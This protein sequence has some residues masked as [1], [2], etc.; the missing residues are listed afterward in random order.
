MP[1]MCNIRVRTLQVVLQIPIG[2]DGEQVATATAF[3]GSLYEPI[4]PDSTSAPK[5]STD[6]G[7]KEAVGKTTTTTTTAAT[8]SRTWAP[9]EE[10]QVPAAATAHL[11]ISDG[12]AWAEVASSSATATAASAQAAPNFPGGLPPS[13]SQAILTPPGDSSTEAGTAAAA[14]SGTGESAPSTGLPLGQLWT[15]GNAYPQVLKI[16]WRKQKISAIVALLDY[17]SVFNCILFFH[18]STTCSPPTATPRHRGVAKGTA[19]GSQRRAG[20]SRRRAGGSQR[21]AGGGGRSLSSNRLQRTTT[22]I[23]TTTTS[24]STTPSSSSTTPSSSSTPCSSST[25]NATTITSSSSTSSSRKMR[26]RPPSPCLRRR[27][28]RRRRTTTPTKGSRTRTRRPRKG[29]RACSCWRRRQ[30]SGENW[31]AAL[32]LS[33]PPLLIWRRGTLTSCTLLRWPCFAGTPSRSTRSV[34]TASGKG[35]Q[36][37]ENTFRNSNM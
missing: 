1:C 34:T 33:P 28:R 12:R 21:R 5:P 37:G 18:C 26:S 35:R 11:G 31:R 6:S 2:E 16:V 20:G 17:G 15:A 23:T 36:G 9:D 10:A 25:S 7:N 22:I 3:L 32:L 8:T 14:T 27:K 24:S 30:R 29:G 13:S 4:S 19:G